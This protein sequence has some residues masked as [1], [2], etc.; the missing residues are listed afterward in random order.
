MEIHITFIDLKIQPSRMFLVPKL[1]SRIDTVL[2]KI[3]RLVLILR[4]EERPEILE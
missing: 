1:I 3:L 2:V 4:G